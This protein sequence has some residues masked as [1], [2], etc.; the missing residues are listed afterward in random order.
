MERDRSRSG[1]LGIA[2]DV[3][4]ATAGEGCYLVAL[5]SASLHESLEADP[6]AR[7]VVPYLVYSRQTGAWTESR[8]AFGHFDQW[9]GFRGGEGRETL[10]QWCAAHLSEAG[11]G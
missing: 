11:G 7:C 5:L 9:T 2:K 3:V 8:G 10:R 6:A 4:V 1:P